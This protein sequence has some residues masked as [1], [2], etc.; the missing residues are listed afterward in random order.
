MSPGREASSPARARSAGAP[1][2]S[3][4]ARRCGAALHDLELERDVLGRLAHEAGD[5]LGHDAALLRPGPALDQ[6]LQVELLGRQSFQ[7]VLADGAEAPLIHVLKQA[8]FEVGIAELA[9]V[10]VPEDALHVGGGQDLADHVEDR[11]VVEGIPDFLELLQQPL[12]DPAFDGVRGHEV[13]DEAVLPLAVAM[14]AAHALFE[15]V[16]VPGDV[17][18][19][20][21]IADLEVDAFAGRLGGHEHLDRA[22]PE[23]LFGVEPRAGFIARARLHAAMDAADLEAPGLELLHEIVERVLELGEEEKPLGPDGRRSPLC[24]ADP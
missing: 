3:G 20:Q 12:E 15:A 22:F 2:A 16:G 14:D 19:E 8:L 5:G 9:R 13:E 10:V 6:H 1:A 18:V 11:I 17:V 24:G 21:D 23:L 7:R 4:R